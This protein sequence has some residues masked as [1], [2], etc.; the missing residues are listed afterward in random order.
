MLIDTN[1]VSYFFKRDTRATAYEPHLR[2]KQLSLSLMTVAEL[3][4]WPIERNFGEAKRQQLVQ[5]LRNYTVL[6]YDDALAW[7]WAELVARTCRA[8]P[9][10]LPDSWIAATAIRHG[11]PVVTHNRQHFD[12]VPGLVVI[13]E[14]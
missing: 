7:A 13:S 8:R 2:G 14:T 1:I 11:L 6:P 5:Y 10:S 12:G 4:K 3:Y 9:M